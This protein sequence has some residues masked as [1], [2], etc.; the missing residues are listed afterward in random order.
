ML[1]NKSQNYHH[2]KL[3][4]LGDIV[5]VRMKTLMPNEKHRKYIVESF[6][7]CDSADSRY[8]VGIHTANL[9]ALGNGEKFRVSGHWLETIE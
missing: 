7:L 1:N 2:S 6:P 5:I 3:P 4:N 9:R 8:S